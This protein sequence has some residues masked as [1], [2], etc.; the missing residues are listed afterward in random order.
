MQG[1]SFNH[2]DF[3][4]AVAIPVTIL[5]FWLTEM[6]AVPVSIDSGDSTYLGSSLFFNFLLMLLSKTNKPKVNG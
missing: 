5:G 1:L 2:S 3:P 4:D 6:T